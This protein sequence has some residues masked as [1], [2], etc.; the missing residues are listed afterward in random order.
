MFFGVGIH[1]QSIDIIAV[2]IS[3][4][5]LKAGK[6]AVH[7]KLAAGLSW[8]PMGVGLEALGGVFKERCIF[9]LFQQTNIIFFDAF[10]DFCVLGRFGL[11]WGLARDFEL[12]DSRPRHRNQEQTCNYFASMLFDEVCLTFKV[13][14][15]EMW[16][17]EDIFEFLDA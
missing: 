7:L 10:E 2:F 12:K 5:F 13:A 14:N 17:V 15:G 9:S 6:F 3:W 11:F 1:S 16:Q 8:D 4:P